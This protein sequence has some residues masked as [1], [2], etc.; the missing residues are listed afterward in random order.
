MAMVTLLVQMEVVQFH[1]QAIHTQRLKILLN[2]STR[3]LGYKSR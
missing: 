1:S 2:I 3:E